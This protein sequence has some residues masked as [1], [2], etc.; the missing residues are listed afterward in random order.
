MCGCA[1]VP[2]GTPLCEGEVV[3]AA[4]DGG[5]SRMSSL[6]LAGASAT[7]WAR[8]GAPSG[9][10][11]VPRI[12]EP[13]ARVLASSSGEELLCPPGPCGSRSRRSGR[14]SRR[15]VGQ[16]R[17]ASMSSKVRLR[18]ARASR[19]IRIRQI[20][21]RPARNRSGAAAGY[22]APASQSAW[23]C[24]SC[25][26]VVYARCGDGAGRCIGAVPLPSW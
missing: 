20:G 13:V 3:V 16:L 23:L 12:D 25:L 4:I 9:S 19:I 10:C 15:V 22:P 6:G 17:P 26:P 21:L 1:E 5:W 14:C 24:R 7:A 2:A 8:R 11:P 18:R